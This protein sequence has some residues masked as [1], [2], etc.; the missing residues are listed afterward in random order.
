MIHI[1]FKN[2]MMKQIKRLGLTAF[3]INMVVCLSAQNTMQAVIPNTWKTINENNYTIQYPDSFGLDKTGQMGTTFILLSK[4]ISQQDMFRENV[5]L[6]IQ[7]LTGK[8]IGLDKYVEI[9]EGQIKTMLQS[10]KIIESNRIKTGNSEFHKILFTG[11]QGQNKLKFEQYYW[12][13]KERAYVLTLTC[14]IDQFDKY[15]D[16]GEKILNSFKI[17]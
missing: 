10:G 14:E 9:S 6:M 11:V 1:T 12:V 13:I 5:N 7:D 3:F 16:V 2:K 15:K 17:Q 4:Q 8:K